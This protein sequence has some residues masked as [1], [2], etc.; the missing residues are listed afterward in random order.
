MSSVAW[1]GVYL[2]ARCRGAEPLVTEAA[3]DL[4]KLDLYREEGK[5]ELV[6]R[7]SLAI[8]CDVAVRGVAE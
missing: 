4:K 1:I 7:S 3:G 6:A 5:A 8:G 2:D